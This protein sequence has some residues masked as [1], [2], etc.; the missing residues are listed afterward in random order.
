[1]VVHVSCTEQLNGSVV[2][3]HNFF[4]FCKS[5]TLWDIHIL[6][7]GFTLCQK[8]L[9]LTVPQSELVCAC[10]RPFATAVVGTASAQLH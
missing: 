9:L 2:S 5:F 8:Y 1:M 6:N 3:C 10:C 7:G 4:M